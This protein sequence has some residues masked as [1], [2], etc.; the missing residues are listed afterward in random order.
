[1]WFRVSGA[2]LGLVWVGM[3]SVVIF[4]CTTSGKKKLSPVEQ[5]QQNKIDEYRAEL[6]VGRNMA[7]RLLQFYGTQ[8][9]IPL[10]EYVNRVGAYVAGYSDYPDRKYMFE[11]IDSEMVNAFACPGGYILVTVGSLRHARNEA[12][13]AGVLAHEIAHVGHKHMFDKLRGMSKEEMDAANE[14]ADRELKDN[15]VLKSRKRPEPEESGFGELVAKY[16]S[17]GGGLSILKAAGAGMAVM[18]DQG[19]GAEKEYEADGYGVKTSVSA[20]YDPESFNEFLC[21]LKNKSSRG[22]CKRSLK[23]VKASKDP[24]TILAKTHPAIEDRI[25][26]IDKVLKEMNAKEIVGAK[27][28]RRFR[29]YRRG[30]PKKTKG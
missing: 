4:S 21:R 28:A 10:L 29:K 24:K 9:N 16:M 17:A 15:P 5:E 26:N 22:N 6:E 27:G 19:L 14:I 13:L 23:K 12:E 18:L 3:L 20:G 8:E 30:L 1:M 7:G 25:A 2:V 11:I